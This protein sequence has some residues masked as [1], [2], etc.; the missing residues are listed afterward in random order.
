MKREKPQKVTINNAGE[1]TIRRSAADEGPSHRGRGAR[2]GAGVI[3]PDIPPEFLAPAKVR[4]EETFV[5]EASPQAR[6]RTVGVPTLDLSVPTGPGEG[7][8]VVLRHASGALTFHA[9]E[10]TVETRR[11]RARGTGPGVAR[12]RIPVRDSSALA[13]DQR[14]GAIGAIAKKIIKVTVLKVIDKLVD[15]ALPLLA[16]KWEES[17]WKNHGLQE[18]WLR[19]DATS[20]RAGKL[21]PWTPDA[22]LLAGGRSLLFIHGTFSNAASAFRNLADNDFFAQVAPLYGDRIFAFDH[23]TVSRTP[24]ENARLLV[25][26]LPSG[27]FEFDVVTHSRGGL[28]LRNLVER[29]DALG[30]NGRRFKLGHAILVASPNEGT[31]LATP[32]RWEKTVG[33][34]A[35]LLELFPDNPLTTG[36]QWIAE[37]L[38][39]LARHASGGLPG[40]GS[41]NGA[42]DLIAALQAPPGP[43]AHGYSALV[44]NFTA[45]AAILARLLDIGVDGFFGI[46]N[47]LVVPTEG[48]WHVDKGPESF[49]DPDR[50][51]CF[52]TGGN[53][54]R[55]TVHHLNYFAQ[56]E[57]VAFILAALMRKPHGLPS[58][59]P[60]RLLP[61]R[62]RAAA[63]GPTVETRSVSPGPAEPQRAP[64]PR[65]T[66]APE[67]TAAQLVPPPPEPADT[68]YLS[69]LDSA[70][71]QSQDALVESYGL[72][73]NAVRPEGRCNPDLAILLA[74]YGS[75]RVI[76]PFRRRGG[77]EG[78]RFGKIIDMQRRLR[79]YIDGEPGTELPKDREFID[80]GTLL[81]E[82]LFPN[83]V[84]RLYDVARS[85]R[86]GERLDLIF[87]SMIPWVADLP[88]EFAY[89]N[90]RGA[91]L[92]TQEIHFVRNV[93]TSIPAEEIAERPLPMRVLVVGA[94]PISEAKLSIDEEIKVIRRGFEPL[95]EAGALDLTVLPRAT[96]QSFHGYISTGQFDVVHF[97]GHGEFGED[98]T[99]HLVFEDGTGATQLLGAR[100]LREIL[101]QRG[102]RL[103]FLNACE[104]AR[105][106]RETANVGAAPALVAGGV[107]AVLANQFK[108]LDQSATAFAQFFYWAVAQGMSLGRAAREARIALNYSIAGETIDWAV[109]V[110]YARNPRAHLCPRVQDEGRNKPSALQL[111]GTSRWAA[112]AARGTRIRRIGVW[113]VA[114][115]FPHLDET[116]ARLN[117]AQPRFVFELVSL[118]APIGTWQNAPADNGKDV[119]YLHAD[120]V[121]RRLQHK[122][123][124]LKVDGLICITNQPMSGP[125]NGR[126][127]PNL[128][129]WWDEPSRPV[130]LISTA[131]FDLPPRG[132][133][134]D[135]TLANAIAVCLLGQYAQ[136]EA[137][138][139]DPKSCI[140][141]YN[142][143]R[144]MEIIAGQR[145]IEPKCRA[146]LQKKIPHDLTAIEQILQAFPKLSLDELAARP[147]TTPIVASG[148]PAQE[149]R[150]QPPSARARSRRP[151]K[152]SPSP[153]RTRP[154]PR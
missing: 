28:V 130:M 153:S 24:E 106:N 59:D 92:A 102:I 60:S 27:E 35:N 88:W 100:S 118:S 79:A 127:T 111:T 18:G 154:R 46:A 10:A 38:V 133:L 77:E 150:S 74:N 128:Y 39:W 78:R 47:D 11:G 33:W 29:S 125:D 86:G 7:S 121:A 23:F 85:L 93:I 58:I 57:A 48:G 119:S 68:F 145:N 15:L 129:A 9:P 55:Q 137:H 8:V 99:G 116:L 67:R 4:V 76:V 114:L 152:K 42:G 32:E 61:S 37:A 104:S 142:P 141:F 14:R 54:A 65:A 51:G 2:R 110:L 112:G 96:P 140:L 122:P 6:R 109:P 13:M 134:V 19:V 124:E 135:K 36:A 146:A 136:V 149:P 98:G 53:L 107:P 16:R 94:Q 22:G 31:P 108:V 50:I 139:R 143:D 101:C 138:G 148:V 5:A 97:I 84:R 132:S 80:F 90:Q 62:R 49:V 30:A 75:A 41:M 44:A 40:I 72:P 89:D 71:Q 21:A 103:I 20:L 144:L 115:A 64:E 12:F 73:K 43:P 147:R 56:P 34:F 63:A 25:D 151:R 45:D 3:A 95:I 120:Q 70:D 87:T 26:A 81:F 82:T 126:P 131:G 1:W 105:D 17:A 66:V 83:D 69:I 123:H 117:A 91:F 113:D 52:G